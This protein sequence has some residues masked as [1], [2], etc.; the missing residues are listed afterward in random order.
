MDSIGGRKSQYHLA[1][2][3]PESGELGLFSA[4]DP[5]EIMQF[6]LV[7]RPVQK[8][9]FYGT[10]FESATALC[11]FLGVFSPEAAQMMLQIQTLEQVEGALEEVA[12][13]PEE[14]G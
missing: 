11:G 5:K 2:Q 3:N 13:G 12:D 4:D 10:N 7:I 8:F 6:L 1:F 9:I 14:L